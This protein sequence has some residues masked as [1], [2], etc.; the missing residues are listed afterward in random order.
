[1]K[2]AVKGFNLEVVLQDVVT[3]IMSIVCQFQIGNIQ[4]ICTSKP[5]MFLDNPWSPILQL[6]GK[7]V[8]RLDCKEVDYL[9]LFSNLNYVHV[10]VMLF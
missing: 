4:S 6:L 8:L 5:I 10:I 3:I 2:S 1:M 7:D 9:Q